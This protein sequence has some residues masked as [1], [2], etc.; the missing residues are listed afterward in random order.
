MSRGFLNEVNL[1]GN[2]GSDVHEGTTRNGTPV[3][4]FQL[5]TNE[6][7]RSEDGD[8]ETV[9]TWHSIVCWSGLAEFL[10]GKIGKSSK[11]FIKGKIQ[12]RKRETRSGETVGVFE[13][14]AKEVVLMD[15][16]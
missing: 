10:S 15:R 7:V 4:N 3:C 16:Y 2:I 8:R 5:V 1:I 9:S 14:V 13:I 6:S 11:V 12:R